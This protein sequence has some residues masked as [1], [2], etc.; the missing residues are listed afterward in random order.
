MRNTA[1][2]ANPAKSSKESRYL[3][4][5]RV[6]IGTRS[7]TFSAREPGGLSRPAWGSRQR[8]R[9]SARSASKQFQ[10]FDAFRYTV[11][12]DLY[13]IIR[14]A[15]GGGQSVPA[16]IRGPH[17]FPHPLR[18]R[19]RRGRTVHARARCRAPKHV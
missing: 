17:G 13:V 10:D 11:T 4:P 1:V 12:L 2:C 3:R 15:A 7:I 18:A 19:R 14:I 9:S 5:P 8:V 16:R 6:I